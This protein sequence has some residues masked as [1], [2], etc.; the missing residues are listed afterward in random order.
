MD[1]S[2]STRYQSEFDFA[3][4]VWNAHRNVIRKKTLFTMTDAVVFDYS[5]TSDKAWG[6]IAPKKVLVNGAI[7]AGL[8]GFNVAQMGPG[9]TA[10]RRMVTL[11]ELG[12][13]L[14]CDENPGNNVMNQGF[15]NP[16]RSSL[17]ASDKA[18]ANEAWR[19]YR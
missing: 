1:W 17:S 16:P 4:G 5:D 9:T 11:H 7:N 10:Q 8:I 18:S 2:G 6:G 14:G 12:H 19:R 3:V 15:T 13:T